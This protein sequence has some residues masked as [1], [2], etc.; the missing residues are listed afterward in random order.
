MTNDLASRIIEHYLNRGHS[1][2]L[3]GRYFCYHLIYFEEHHTAMGA[4]EREK[5]I[6]IGPVLKKKRS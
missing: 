3:A 4:I 5:E 2:T 6:K 1:K